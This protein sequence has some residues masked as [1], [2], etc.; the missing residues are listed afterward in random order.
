VTWVRPRGGRLLL[1]LAVVTALLVPAVAWLDFVSVERG[2]RLYRSGEHVP[3]IRV[4]RRHVAEGVR[5]PVVDYNLGTAWQA[6]GSPSEAEARLREAAG[7]EEREIRY[8]A[9]YN[10]GHLLLVQ[11]LG[12]PERE[13]AAPL[14]GEAVLAYREALR[15]RPASED[16]RWNLAVAMAALDS[17]MMRQIA[18]QVRIPTRSDPMLD[19]VREEGGTLADMGRSGEEGG[20][21][22][23][24]DVNPEARQR[25]GGAGARETLADEAA[26][27]GGD[28]ELVRILASVP[29]DPRHLVRRILWL[30]GP[31]GWFGSQTARGGKW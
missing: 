22:G 24:A 31:K 21:P 7:A 10:L 11:A 20:E 23:E 5:Q 8:R 3:A 25:P 16:A 17:V 19:E 2:N 9:S 27:T 26:A 30:E 18:G 1:W 12:L 15:V 29:D 14:L 28:D 6:A 4:Y 13:M